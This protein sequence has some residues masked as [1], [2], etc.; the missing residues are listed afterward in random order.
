MWPLV[1][2]MMGSWKFTIWAA[3]M[4]APS[5]PI[6]AMFSEVMSLL[7]LRQMKPMAAAAMAHVPAA[8]GGESNS[9]CMCMVGFLVILVKLSAYEYQICVTESSG[10]CFFFVCGHFFWD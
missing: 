6:I 4:K 10:N 5:R 3:K 9:F 7:A 1:P 2:G 8:T